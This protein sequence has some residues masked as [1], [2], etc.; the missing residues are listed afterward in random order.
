[1]T[2]SKA[3]AARP[4]AAIILLTDG[5]TT[6]GRSIGDVAEYARLKTI[7][8]Y[9]I[10]LGNEKSPRDLRLSDLLVEEVVFVGDVVNFDFKLTGSGYAGER[11]VLRLKQKEDS[12]VLAEQGVTVGQDDQPQSVRI[13]YR[14]PEKG[15]FEYVVEVKLRDDEANPDNNRQ[16]RTVSVR[17]ET[18]R[19]LLV[20]AYPSYEFR[21]L[22]TLLGRQLKRSGDGEE[23]SVELTT[24]LQEAGE[25]FAE[26]DETARTGFSR[27]S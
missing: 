9:T 8:L 24:V 27:Q 2:S 16:S 3:S 13:A 18:I 21:Y 12:R 19:V 22:K 6:E 11:V 4:T 5:V 25:G 10:G 23:K 15:E 1:M 26:L 20:Q 7:P 17:D 14:P